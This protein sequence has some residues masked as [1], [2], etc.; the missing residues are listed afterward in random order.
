MPQKRLFFTIFCAIAALLVAEILC[1]GESIAQPTTKQESSKQSDQNQPTVRRRSTVVS[2]SEGTEFW[3][4]FEKNSFTEPSKDAG[5]KR[6]TSPEAITLELFLSAGETARVTI[7]ID[8]LLFKRTVTVRGGTVENVH[9]DT[10]AQ[11]RSSERAERLAVHVTSD[12][13]IGLYGLNHRFMTTDTY[14]GLPVTAL[15]QEYRVISYDKLRDDPLLI[16]QFAVIATQDSTSVTINPTTPTFGGSPKGVPFTVMLK[17]GDVYQVIAAPGRKYGKADLTGTLVQSNKKIAVFGS[18][19]GA[20]I[21]QNEKKGYNHLVEQLPPVNFWGRHYYVGT[22]SGCTRSVFRVLAAENTTKVFANGQLVAT[23]AAGEFYED[24]NAE[25]NIQISADKRILVAQYSIGYE[26]GQGKDLRDSIGDPMMLLLTPTQ[27]FIKKYRIATPVRGQWNHYFNLVVP[28]QAAHTLRFNGK[29]VN[30]DLFKPFGES[31]YT[32]A[33]LEVPYGTHLVE[34]EEPFGLYSYGFGYDQNSYDAYGNMGGQSF[35]EMVAVKDSLPPMADATT[36]GS[37]KV[38]GRVF[39]RDDREDDRGLKSLKILRSEGFSLSEPSVSAGAPQVELLI[40]PPKPL[41]NGRA[42]VEAADVAGNK[43]LFTVCYVADGTGSGFV[44]VQEGDNP[45]CP[46]PS[47]W[48]VG[49][50]GSLTLSSN[51]ASF[52]SIGALDGLGGTFTDVQSSTIAL[53]AGGV[54][55]GRKLTSKLSATARL[56]L[57]GFPGTVRASDK[58]NLEILD[59]AKVPPRTVPFQESSTVSLN[60]QYLSLGVAAEWSLTN[61]LYALLGLKASLA[62]SR[63]VTLKRQIL[64]PATFAYSDTKSNERTEFNG[65]VDALQTLIPSVMIG[66]GVEVP[67]WRQFSF[68]GEFLYSAPFGGIISGG[69]WTVS[70][71][72]LNVGVRMKL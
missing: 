42:L 2:T 68:C 46:S 70:Q 51:S 57:E 24:T 41:E 31:R 60:N 43:T 53:S 9:I 29:A 27:Q 13:P 49:V 48:F 34:C 10:A 5:A 62:L 28:R 44:S 50:F 63:T 15:G 30:M 17:K 59:T 66:F 54:V 7:E 40:I 56:A 39:I 32:I 58:R 8:G 26:N 69:D 21:P 37:G 12:K 19:S 16:S 52:G 4:C 36:L 61:N 72:V 64:Q 45:A 1:S 18:H 35:I 3:V 55:V 71:L 23:L 22:L 14:L 11:I 67:V 65:D 20:Y 38:G 47:S 25:D 6:S 33:Q